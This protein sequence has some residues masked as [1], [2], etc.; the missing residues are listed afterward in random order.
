MSAYRSAGTRAVLLVTAG[1]LLTQCSTPPPAAE[2]VSPAEAAIAPI[3]SIREL[4]TYIIDPASDGVFDAVGA[5]VT[6]AGVVETFP[7][8]DDDWAEVQR[9]AL[10]MAEGM[11]LLRLPR[12]VAPADD[13]VAKNPGELPPAEVE[14]K[15]AAS[16]ELWASHI[17][18]LQQ[19]AMK[20]LDIVKARQGDQLFDAGSAIDAACEA[21]HLDFWY[22]GDREAVERFNNST[23]T[24]D[25]PAP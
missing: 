21:C 4:M 20:V 15:I 9:G 11:N 8:T 12:R 5:D 7:E 3:V 19:E 6:D 17:D 23:T 24:F 13:N 16:P 25:P 10:T 1:I 22:P 2:V 18:R 14:A